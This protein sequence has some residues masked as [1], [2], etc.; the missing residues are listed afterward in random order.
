MDVTNYN[1]N[2][3]N[4]V[5]GAQQSVQP[6]QPVPAP[7]ETTTVPTS[8]I[9][10]K[11]LKNVKKTMGTMHVVGEEAKIREFLNKFKRLVQENEHNVLVDCDIVDDEGNFDVMDLT[12]LSDEE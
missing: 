2:N 8:N 9:N 1:S 7:V 10:A 3:I 4:P 6:T 5:T 11:D 12:A